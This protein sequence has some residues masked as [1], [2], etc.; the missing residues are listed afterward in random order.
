MRYLLPPDARIRKRHE[1]DTLFHQGEFFRGRVVNIWVDS[2]CCD[3]KDQTKVG[4]IVSR[5]VS[6]RANERNR[7][8]RRV[9]E[10][11]RL[12]RPSVKPGTRVLVQA[13]RFE[14][15]ATY[16]EIADDLE[17]LLTKSGCLKSSEL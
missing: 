2:S 12:I 11:F 7:I 13:K 10:A 14:T 16:R 3:Y 1:F 5:K 4:I 8:K 6:L 9:K 15:I 17:R